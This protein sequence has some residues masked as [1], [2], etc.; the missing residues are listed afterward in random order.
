MSSVKDG[1]NS[2]PATELDGIDKSKLVPIPQ[3]PQHLFGL[4]GTLNDHSS[5]LRLIEGS[6]ANGNWR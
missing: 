2:A 1:K 4:L 5:Y 6:Y 3:P